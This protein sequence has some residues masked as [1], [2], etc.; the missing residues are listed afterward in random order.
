MNNIVKFAEPDGYQST[1]AEC[2]AVMESGA[3]SIADVARAIGRGASQATISQWLAGKYAGDV[4]AV[5]ARVRRWLDTRAELAAHDLSA[6][7]L[8][9]HVPYRATA[10]VHAALTF[11]QAEGDITC[12]HG[13]SG[14]G[15]SM[16]LR[17]Y[18][19]THSGAFCIVMTGAVRSLAGML[20]RVAAAVG[21]GDWH[22]SALAAETAIVGQLTGRDTLL[23]VDEAHH[24]T[25]QL[26]DELRCIRDISGCGLALAGDDTLWTVLAGSRRCDQIVGRIAMRIPLGQASDDDV[27]ELAQRIIGF[28][29]EGAAAERVLGAARSPGGL[30]AVR[31]VFAR[32]VTRARAAGRAMRGTDIEGAA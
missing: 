1:L 16:A 19:E 6:A 15:K 32:A 23:I 4:E 12:V 8:D 2:R 24:L 28:R 27:L 5:T 31:R 26:L 25:P 14:A 29:P 18:A 30:H 3:L 10:G 7:G 11:A 9:R 21:A 20:A 13:R 17:H 22:R